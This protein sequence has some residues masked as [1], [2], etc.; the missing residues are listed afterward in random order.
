MLSREQFQ[1]LTFHD[2]VLCR[3]HSWHLGQIVGSAGLAENSGQT[4]LDPRLAD[5]R[6]RHRGANTVGADRRTCR[7][8]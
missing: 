8:W 5:A 4:V 2:P 7:A 6:P 1:T 3:Q